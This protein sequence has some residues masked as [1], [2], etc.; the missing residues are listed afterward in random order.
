VER[1]HGNRNNEGVFLNEPKKAPAAGRINRK[2]SKEI[3]R[4]VFQEMLD[5]DLPTFSRAKAR[6]EVA[7]KARA[8]LDGRNKNA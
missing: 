6:R 4:E 7:A 2:A 8:K 5:E 1:G 3:V